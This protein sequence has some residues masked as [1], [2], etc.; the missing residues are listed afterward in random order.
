[1]GDIILAAFAVIYL[2]AWIYLLHDLR[3]SSK[4]ISKETID[5]LEQMLK[6]H[7]L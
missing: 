1:M 3:R 7:H 2:A 6:N 5:H 4:P